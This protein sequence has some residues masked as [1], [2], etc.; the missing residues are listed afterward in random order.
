MT[1]P[2][3]IAAMTKTADQLAAAIKGVSEGVLSKRPD[4]KNWAAKEVI[5]HL[6]DTEELFV[7]RIQTILNANEPPLAGAEQE[8][9]AVERQYLRNDAGEAIAAFRGRREDMLK[10]LQSLQANQWERGGVHATYGRLTILEIVTRIVG[11][12]KNHLD[13]LQRALNGQP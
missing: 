9:W 12:D 5:C 3:L 6:R 2:E 4:G 7:N 8:R 13:Q 11:H 10:L 1:T